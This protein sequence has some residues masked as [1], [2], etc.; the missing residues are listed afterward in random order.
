MEIRSESLIHH[1]REAVYLAYRDRLPDIARDF[2]PDI[3][4][5]LVHA[6]TEGEGVIDLH[7]EWVSNAEL[8][9]VARKLLSPDMLRWE[10]FAH[11]DDTGHYVDWR[12]R[13]RAF[14]EQ[15]QC[16]GRNS[17]V[18]VDAN[19]TKVLLLGELKIDLR[20]IR[21]V[22]NI[23]ARRIAPTLEKFIV[24]MITPNLKKV[25]ESLQGFLDAQ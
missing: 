21:G 2:M 15:V 18:E 5:I 13:T 19:T 25:N 12:L 3:K 4:E 7:N 24:G 11:W 1:P 14:T 6:R 20:D 10:D 8:P 9:K 23:V 22:P 17:F 16:S